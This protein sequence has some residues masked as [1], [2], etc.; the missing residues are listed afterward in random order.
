MVLSTAIPPAKRA[1]VRDL[2]REELRRVIPAEWYVASEADY[3]PYPI[4]LAAPAEPV[5]AILTFG[6]GKAFVAFRTGVAEYRRGT[7]RR[8]PVSL[9]LYGEADVRNRLRALCAGMADWRAGQLGEMTDL[10]ARMARAT[11]VAERLAAGAEHSRAVAD[12]VGEVPGVWQFRRDGMVFSYYFITRDDGRVR[13]ELYLTDD[14]IV[15]VGRLLDAPGGASD[16][17][18]GDDDN[19]A[20]GGADGV[21]GGDRAGAGGLAG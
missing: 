19:P 15:R 7:N 16:A 14:E 20:G 4:K 2:L 13:A 1:Q 3:R 8:H 11:A 9:A 5:E 17:G 6:G 10:Q 21:A 18:R 12:L